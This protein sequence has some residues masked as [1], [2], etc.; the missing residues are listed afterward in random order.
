[1]ENSRLA[2]Y[3]AIGSKIKGFYGKNYGKNEMA[4]IAK[5]V[6]LSTSTVYKIVQFVEKYNWEDIEEISEGAFQ[7][8]WHRLRDNLSLQKEEVIRVYRASHNIAEFNRKIKE[9]KRISK[10]NHE[11]EQF[12][13]GVLNLSAQDSNKKVSEKVTDLPAEIKKLQS[14]LDQKN[15]QLDT[16]RKVLKNIKIEWMARF[17][18]ILRDLDKE[19]LKR[20]EFSLLEEK[21]RRETKENK[22][23]TAIHITD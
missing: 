23:T 6:D 1:M 5:T 14:E 22:E 2:A 13:P 21:K 16:L 4:K 15:R 20:L 12:C 17:P 19:D 7:L 8:S 10:C 9:I 3:H 18:E 11:P